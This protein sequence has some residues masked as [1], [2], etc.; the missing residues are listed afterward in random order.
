MSE[1]PLKMYD[2]VRVENHDYEFRGTVQC[3]WR[4]RNGNVRF[5]IE[6]DRGVCLI[7]SLRNLVLIIRETGEEYPCRDLIS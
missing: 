1:T 7:Q 3:I 5:V 6:D 2:L 4:K